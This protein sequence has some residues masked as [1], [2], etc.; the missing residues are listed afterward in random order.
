MTKFAALEIRLAKK[1]LAS[2]TPKV[3]A[4]P[5][6]KQGGV[7]SDGSSW[8]YIPA[9]SPGTARFTFYISPEH[10]PASVT[11][12][13]NPS[14]VEAILGSC[15]SAR[16]IA[17]VVTLAARLGHKAVQPSNFTPETG[18]SKAAWRKQ[19]QL[20]SSQ[21]TE[22][23]LRAYEAAGVRGLNPKLVKGSILMT[24]FG[25][26]IGKRA[27]TVKWKQITGDSHLN[28]LANPMT[29]A[30]DWKA[31]A[32]RVGAKIPKAIVKRVQVMVDTAPSV[33]TPGSGS[34]FD[35]QSAVDG[36]QDILTRDR[37]YSGLSMRVRSSDAASLAATGSVSLVN[38]MLSDEIGDV[39]YA[40]SLSMTMDAKGAVTASF[41]LNADGLQNNATG[42]ISP[43][44]N[45][46]GQDLAR[47][48]YNAVNEGFE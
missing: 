5:A 13:A 40:F 12:K 48:F 16:S 21:A 28:V 14:S 39:D 34:G 47:I 7:F 15:M 43:S 1:Y 2:R 23:V 32:V 22:F 11:V 31:F 25:I 46:P 36:F 26:V 42:V 35:L 33:P 37:Q 18:E 27:E 9:R 6:I 17:D 4:D 10:A 45:Q 41:S 19:E 8:D 29:T 30:A 24:N 38:H 44:S 3:A 20:V